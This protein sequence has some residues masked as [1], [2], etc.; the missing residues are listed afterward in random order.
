QQVSSRRDIFQIFRAIVSL[1]SRLMVD[2]ITLRAR[3]DKCKSNKPMYSDGLLFH[4]APKHYGVITLLVERGYQLPS[5][6]SID[7][8]RLFN[9]AINASNPS[10]ATYLIPS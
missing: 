2:V 8:I 6:Q 10:F 1:V 3:P 7:S 4:L 5:V 9:D